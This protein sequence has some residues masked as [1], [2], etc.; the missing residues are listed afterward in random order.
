[1]SKWKLTFALCTLNS[2]GAER[3]LGQLRGHLSSGPLLTLLSLRKL[4]NSAVP[5][6]QMGI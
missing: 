3:I 6:S 2:V 5:Q 1:M 4:A